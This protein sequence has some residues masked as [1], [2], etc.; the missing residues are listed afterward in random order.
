MKNSAA[1]WS[2]EFYSPVRKEEKRNYI[3]NNSIQFNY[4]LCAG[5]TATRS[6]TEATQEHKKSTNVEWTK[7]ITYKRDNKKITPTNNSVNNI[8]SVKEKFVKLNIF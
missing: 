2:S 6:I 7:A 3:N 8:M 5:T 4:H 1:E